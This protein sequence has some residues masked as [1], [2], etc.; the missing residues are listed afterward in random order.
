MFRVEVS[1]FLALQSFKAQRES[2]NLQIVLNKNPFTPDVEVP[3]MSSDWISRRSRLVIKV[4]PKHPNSQYP[5]Q[6]QFYLLPNPSSAS[7][8]CRVIPIITSASSKRDNVGI[9]YHMLT[10]R[11]YNLWWRIICGHTFT[12]WG[13]LYT[14][15]GMLVCKSVEGERRHPYLGI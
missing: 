3:F 14:Q 1:L 15:D 2:Q 10:L 11:L 7:R 5:L 12:C 9:R 4:I 6:L 8:L 13:T